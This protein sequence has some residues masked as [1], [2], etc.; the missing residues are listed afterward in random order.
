MEETIMPTASAHLPQA[1]ADRVCGHRIGD[2]IAFDRIPI[3]TAS[4]RH[5]E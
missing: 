3:Q 4:P 5:R 1:S 2:G